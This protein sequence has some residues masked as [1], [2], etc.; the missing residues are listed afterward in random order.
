MCID[1]II[2]H[3]FG[4]NMS[5]T[6]N[7]LFMSLSMVKNYFCLVRLVK[8][9]YMFQYSIWEQIYLCKLHVESQKKQQL[10]RSKELSK[11]VHN[12]LPFFR[13]G[14]AFWLS[15][16][17]TLIVWCI[18]LVF[19]LTCEIQQCNLQLPPLTCSFPGASAS[20]VWT[21]DREF[22]SATEESNSSSLEDKAQ[23]DPSLIG[24]FRRSGL[25]SMRIM[26]LLSSM[27]IMLLLSLQPDYLSVCFIPP[28][29]TIMFQTYYYLFTCY[30]EQF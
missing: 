5:I 4:M 6:K 14:W 20:G 1:L 8:R 12:L 25:L 10:F 16:P 17:I 23:E 9:L 30:A 11:V 21:S 15:C 2:F 22:I 3:V 18:I 13:S 26:L 29:N 24:M 28:S 7:A 19:H 27:R